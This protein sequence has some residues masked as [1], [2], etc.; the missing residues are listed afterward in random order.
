MLNLP[1]SRWLSAIS[2]IEEV[3]TSSVNFVVMSV[4]FVAKDN[5]KLIL[6]IN[7]YHTKKVSRFQARDPALS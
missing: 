4:C 2:G 3:V 6:E 1:F 5:C 7:R